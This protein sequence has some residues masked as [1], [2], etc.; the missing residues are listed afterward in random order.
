VQVRILAL[1][2]LMVAL[3][4]PAAAGSSVRGTSGLRGV[5]MRGPIRPVCSAEQPCDAPAPHVKLTFRDGGVSRTTTTDA[6]GHYALALPAG[7]YS[8]VIA[9]GRFGYAPKI[10][11]VPAGRVAVRNFS[12]DTGIR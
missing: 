11:A 5:V 10:V 9:A 6:H 4:V 7:S 8:V 3:V 12:I 2:A 1:A